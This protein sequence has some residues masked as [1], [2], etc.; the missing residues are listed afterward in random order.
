ME[1]F[2]RCC[3]SVRWATHMAHARPFDSVHD[4]LLK[5]QVAYTKMERKDWL[6]A[7]AAHPKIGEGT[8][9]KKKFSTTHAWASAEQGG[10]AGAAKVLLDDLAEANQEYENKNGFIFI[11]CA[12]GKSPREMLTLL[13]AR[14]HNDFDTEVRNA[15]EEQKKITSL[16]LEKLFL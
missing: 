5:V 4:L 1:Q 11:V 8:A 16:R 3:G 9:I 7:F 13:Q 6:E 15:A 14:L 2:L 12:T 10:M